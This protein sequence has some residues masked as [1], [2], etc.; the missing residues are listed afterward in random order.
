M[1]QQQHSTVAATFT[2]PVR[3]GYFHGLSYGDS[4][5]SSTSLMT[6][7]IQLLGIC[8]RNAMKM[9]TLHTAYL[10]Y[11]APGLAT[12]NS[13]YFKDAACSQP[14]GTLPPSVTTKTPTACTAGTTGS[15]GFYTIALVSPTAM[16]FPA[17]TC[18]LTTRAYS[19]ANC[20]G[21]LLQVND[22]S[23]ALP[24]FFLTHTCY[25]RFCR[26]RLVL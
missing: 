18:A 26:P 21:S 4:A 2:N 12:L 14:S 10:G 24:T 13:S 6:A 3:N 22:N 11:P 16:N 17:T 1:I 20:S 19:Y 9:Y 7:K 8:Y 23:Y 5:C 25:G 15:G